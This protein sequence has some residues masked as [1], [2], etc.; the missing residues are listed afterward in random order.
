MV[1]RN[2]KQSMENAVA[3]KDSNLTICTLPRCT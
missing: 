3:T 1:G 2:A